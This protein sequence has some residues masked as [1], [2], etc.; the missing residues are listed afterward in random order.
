MIPDNHWDS[1]VYLGKFIP[2]FPCRES[3]GFCHLRGHSAISRQRDLVRPAAKV[4]G[5][6]R[7]PPIPNVILRRP[8]NTRALAYVATK[9]K[10][11]FFWY[12]KRHEA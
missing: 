6:G 10:S 7:L 9:R 3:S 12:L 5:D 11:E 2:L 1:P 8:L 4:V